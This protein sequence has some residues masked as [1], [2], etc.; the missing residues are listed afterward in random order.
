MFV[1]PASAA[2]VAGLLAT[3][4]DG[5]LP[6][7]SLVVCTVTGHGLK[8]P[9]TALAGMSSSDG[10]PGGRCGGGRGAR[11]GMS[12][13][14]RV[15]IRVPAT[16]ANLGPGYD[17]FGLALARHDEVIAER[18]D[19]GLRLEVAGVGADT[20]PRTV[21]HLVIRS[22]AA[23]FA[24]MDEP[25]P[26]LDVKCTNTFRTAGTGLVGRGDRRR[27]VAGRAGSPPTAPSRLPDDALLDLASRLEGHPDNVAAAL[28]GGFTLAWIDDDGRARAVGREVHPAVRAVVFAARQSSA[29]EHAR[30]ALP[31]T[32]PHARRGRQRG[33]GSVAGPCPHRPTR[34]CCSRPPGTGCTSRTG[35]PATL[36][37]PPCWTTCGRPAS[38]R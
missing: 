11:P 33:A 18:T 6:K 16:S 27:T 24:V 30:A 9:E 10:D 34:R 21:E 19:G 22:A 35:G 4:A 31:A 29:T 37:R 17:C 8:D 5:R 20:V 36:R 23:G 3:T 13:P 28:F 25:L 1:E 15:R 2:S 7:G 26:G 14:E 38:P 32:V 12:A